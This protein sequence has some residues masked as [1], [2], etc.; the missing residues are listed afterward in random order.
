MAKLEKLYE[1]IRNLQEL[2]LPLNQET[3]QAADNLEEQLI[4]SEILP[5]MSRNVEPLLSQIQRDLV[6]VVEY[7]PGSPIS[8][9]LSRKAKITEI[10][11]AKQLTPQSPADKKISTPVV[12][13]KATKYKEPHTPTRCVENPT[14]GLKVEFSDG[15]VIC[16]K[17]A[18]ET[19]VASLRKIGFQ[20]IATLD[21][22]HGK[23]YKL[24]SKQKRTPQNGNVWQHECDGWFI[25]S[26]ISNDQKIKDLEYISRQ[27]HIKLKITKSKPKR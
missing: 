4:K 5:A 15:E 27:L 2:G 26:N 3:L 12:S 1:S 7:H 10:I 16:R 22:T 14:K 19:F 23:S 8:V 18:I 13:D 21:I 25:Y 24:V 20:R 6:L 9:A 17:T 11:D